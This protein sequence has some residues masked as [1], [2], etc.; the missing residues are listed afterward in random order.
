MKCSTTCTS[1]SG[2]RARSISFFECI[3][4]K[5]R[6]WSG[7]C[8]S[9]IVS[10]GTLALL[11]ALPCA[12]FTERCRTDYSPGPKPNPPAGYSDVTRACLCDEDGSN[13]KWVWA[14]TNK[15]NAD[16]GILD[17][18]A[19][20]EKAELT[21]QQ[22][23][24]VEMENQA[25]MA[26]LRRQRQLA[27]YQRDQQRFKESLDEAR[28]VHPDFDQLVKGA[29]TTPRLQRQLWKSKHAGELVYWLAKNHDEHV[30]IAALPDRD[31]HRELQKIEKTLTQAAR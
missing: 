28:F 27:R 16:G 15:Q 4:G 5:S 1:L 23:R 25:R 18:I 7:L 17:A 13:C 14:G 11:L 24:A 21:R 26:E 10:R 6:T 20:P 29:A 9:R 30:R 31:M 19:H 3:S 12:A 2:S 8:R 22:A